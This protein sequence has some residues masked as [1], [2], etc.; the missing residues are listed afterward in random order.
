MVLSVLKNNPKKVLQ[1]YANWKTKK[2][3]LSFFWKKSSFLRSFRKTP[4]LFF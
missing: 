4:F 1:K 3:K 2:K